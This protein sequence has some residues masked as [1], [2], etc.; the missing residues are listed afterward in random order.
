MVSM[1]QLKQQ[2]DMPSTSGIQK[3]KKK[4]NL[5]D[6]LNSHNQVCIVL[7]LGLFILV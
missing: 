4:Q 2:Y 7:F 3:N 1:D 5:L 6:A